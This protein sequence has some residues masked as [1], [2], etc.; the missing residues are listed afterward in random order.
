MENKDFDNELDFVID[1]SFNETETSK[2]VKKADNKKV[3]KILIPIIS[4][5]LIIAVAAFFGFKYL[6]KKWNNGDIATPA[7]LANTTLFDDNFTYFDSVYVNGVALNGLTVQEA[8]AEVF[9]KSQK[10]I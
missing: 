3:L 2:T 7:F 8:E 10:Y 9:K 5:V 1:D 4:A 6:I